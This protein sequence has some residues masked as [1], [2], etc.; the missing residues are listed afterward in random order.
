MILG[1]DVDEVICPLMDKVEVYLKEE[2]DVDF[3]QDRLTH[4][5]L[6]Y[7]PDIGENEIILNDL[8]AKFSDPTLS[9]Y[10]DCVANPAGVSVIRKLK[11]AG[12]LIYFISGRPV[13]AEV[14]TATWLRKNKVPF[15]YIKHVGHSDKGPICRNLKLDFYMDDNVAGIESVLK[16]KQSWKL[17]LAIFDRPWN[18]DYNN[19]RVI[20]VTSWYDMLRI[21]G[22]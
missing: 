9:F 16:H 2:Y 6:K 17:G 11:R 5:S 8:K 13:G 3:S 21:V 4:F 18:R 19:S 12:H 1:F 20:R 15:N 10:A 22:I 14:K 7:S